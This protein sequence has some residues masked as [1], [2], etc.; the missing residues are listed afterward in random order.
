V[1]APARADKPPRYQYDQ[2]FDFGKLH[3]FDIRIDESKQREGEMA[4]T[5]VPKLVKLLEDLLIAKG[6]SIET[7]HPDFVLEWDTMVAADTSSVSWSG[8]GEIAKG[9]LALRM[10]QPAQQEPFWIGADFADISGKITPDKAWKKVDRAG[11]RI[12][13][14]FPP[15]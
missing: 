6:Y 1:A 9:M 3:T 12:L 4:A 13:E 8:H 11:R 15:K 7:E 2:A 5:V 14:G 10:R